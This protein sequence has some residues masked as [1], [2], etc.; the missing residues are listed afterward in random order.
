MHE[1]GLPIDAVR[2]SE[3]G[4][5][6]YCL[7]IVDQNAERTFFTK[8]GVESLFDASII[9]RIEYFS[10]IYLTGYFL[11]EHTQIE[12]V[13]HY[14]RTCD[15]PIYFDPGV[16]IGE[17]HPDLLQQILD[18]CYAVTPNEKEFKM[19]KNFNL[20]HVE[21]IIQKRG[22]GIITAMKKGKEYTSYPYDVATVDTTGAGD[23]FIGA[24]M[25]QTLE[26][27]PLDDALKIA[28]AAASYMT[29]VTGPHQLFD[30][31]DIIRIRNHSQE[32]RPC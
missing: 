13:L 6:G 16:L 2:K 20:G 19:L 27:A 21:I 5:T 31:D 4:S 7:T 14:L 9:P 29:T 15:V 17:I 18:L 22:K 32:L 1:R 25:A 11:L 30:R 8:K 3:Q 26:G 23:C 24:F 28:S 12:R 10:S